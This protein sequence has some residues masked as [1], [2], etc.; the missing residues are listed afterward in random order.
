MDQLNLTDP[1]GRT[2]VIDLSNA[3]V[4][5]NP[6]CKHVFIE[7]PTDQTDHYVAMVCVDC[8]I[9]YLKAK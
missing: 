3:R 8:P 7:D 2:E 4:I 6:N 1:E 5:T 9:G